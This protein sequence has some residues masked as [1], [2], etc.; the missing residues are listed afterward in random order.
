MEKDSFK[1]LWPLLRTAI[2]SFLLLW[3]APTFLF[4]VYAF[5]LMGACPGQTSSFLCETFANHTATGFIQWLTFSLL[6]ISVLLLWRRELP[7]LQRMPVS[8]FWIAGLAFGSLIL[9]LS[10][11]RLAM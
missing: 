5:G 8:I 10:P 4:M 6:S 2:V 1:R 9:L 11:N 7:Q 3:Y